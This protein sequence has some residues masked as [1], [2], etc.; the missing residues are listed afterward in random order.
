M[1]LNDAE[2]KS[3]DAAYASGDKNKINQLTFGMAMGGQ[4]D[5]AG[6]PM[7]DMGALLSDY[8]KEYDAKQAAQPAA[9]PPPAAG[10]V[11][12]GQP[13]NLGGT[14][15]VSAQIQYDKEGR[16]IRNDYLS[17]QDGEGNLQK[18]LS[19]GD[20]IGPD[21]QANTQG[22]DAIRA[23]AL[24]TGPS[25]WANLANAK[26][27]VEQATAMDMANKTSAQGVNSAFNNLR[28]KGGL[29]AG[30]RERLAMQGSR[31]AATSQQTVQRQGLL[32]RAGIGMQDQ[33]SK[34]Q[35][36]MQLPG[37]DLNQANFQQGQRSF[38]AQANQYDIGNKLKDIGGFNAY[39]SDAYGKAMQEWSASKIA[40]VQARAGGGGKK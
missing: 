35:M 9:P 2:K 4:M 36:L 34:D 12:T 38:T 23:R 15:G 24:S 25:A 21:V 7:R 39:N 33:Q 18:G 5:S 22:L 6:R 30:Q 13:Q 17:I 8:R 29:S 40:D 14:T 11:S 3:L 26:Q 20:K 32:D 10:T 28:A 1:S 16:P 37:M 19:M 27:G 31:G